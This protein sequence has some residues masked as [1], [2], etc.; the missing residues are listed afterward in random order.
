[1]NTK[2]QSNQRNLYI[3]SQ[4]VLQ[5]INEVVTPTLLNH[6]INLNV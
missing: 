3:A 2:L 5:E 6:D 4:I 1:M